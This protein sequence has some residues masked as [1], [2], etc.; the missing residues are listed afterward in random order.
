MAAIF[1]DIDGTLVDKYNKIEESTIRGIK[2]LQANG[3][4]VYINS[5]RTRVYIHNPELHEIGFDG[6]FSLETMARWGDF[7]EE[8][9]RR[10]QKKLADLSKTIAG[11]A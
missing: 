3:H 4:A 9:F 1:F 2:C 5:G 7:P 6:T 10:N 11:I 8:E